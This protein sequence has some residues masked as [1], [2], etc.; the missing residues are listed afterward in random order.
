M[1]IFYSSHPFRHLGMRRHKKK[2]LVGVDHIVFYVNLKKEKK[3]KFWLCVDFVS[4]DS[5]DNG[6]SFISKL[7]SRTPL[8]RSWFAKW[9]VCERG[10]ER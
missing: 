7:P 6:G 3:K 4:G 9:R 1:M 10:E 5:S 2:N 8:S